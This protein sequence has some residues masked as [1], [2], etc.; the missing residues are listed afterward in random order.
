MNQEDELKLSELDTNMTFLNS[1]E[2]T[3]LIVLQNRKLL[4]EVEAMKRALKPQQKDS[5]S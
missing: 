2:L 5:D 3:R 4:E 1:A